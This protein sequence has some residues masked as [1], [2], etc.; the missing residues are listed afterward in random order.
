MIDLFVRSGMLGS[1]SDG[2]GKLVAWLKNSSSDHGNCI[3]HIH[4]CLSSG[5]FFYPLLRCSKALFILAPAGSFV[6]R[7]V[8]G[9]LTLPMWF[10]QVS[11]SD[12]ESR[13]MKIGCCRS[14]TASGLVCLFD[15]FPA[16]ALSAAVAAVGLLGT[17]VDVCA[18]SLALQAL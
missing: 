6:P 16:V 5:P 7:I 9:S 13:E 14:L 10:F 4:C 18:T 1:A 11:A 2:C 3:S 15:C 17:M 12:A 8:T